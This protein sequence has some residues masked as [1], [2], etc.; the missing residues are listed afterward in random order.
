MSI[1]GVKPG[2]KGG[3]EEIAAL[4]IEPY[5]RLRV[6]ILMRAIYDWGLCTH[7]ARRAESTGSCR[8]IREFFQSDWCDFLMKGIEG[9][10]KEEI[11]EKLEASRA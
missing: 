11:L 9:I 8:E 5:R 1:D 3:V 4:D 10:S 6:A 7:P 2:K